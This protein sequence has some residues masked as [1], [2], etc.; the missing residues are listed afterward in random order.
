MT[1]YEPLQKVET[2]LL[3]RDLGGAIKDMEIFLSVHPHQINSDRLYAIQSD[4]QLMTDYWRRGYK[5]PKLPEL[6]D[7][8]LRRMYQLYANIAINYRVRHSSQLSDL[9]LKVQM[10]GRD[11]S[12]QVIREDLEAFVSDIALLDLE[13][14]HVAA[15]K[16]QAAYSHHQEL[17][18]TLFY[19]ILTAGLWTDGF[20]KNM[21]EMLLSPTIDS[22]DQQVLVSSVMLSAM[23]QFDIAKFRTLVNVYAQATD[24]NVRQR[25][26][27][28]W[29]FS[30]DSEV[31]QRLYPEE[32]KLVETLLESENC[33]RE[34]AELQRQ[35]TY[36]VNAERDKDALQNDIIPDL[37]KQQGWK[38]TRN[39]LVE[40]DEDDSLNDIL[41]PDE[42]ERKLEKLE[43]SFQ[44]ML[45]MQKQGADIYF[46]GFSLMK[47][48]SFFSELSNWFMPF[49][50][51]HPGIRNATKM[52][53]DNP[54]VQTMMN[55]APFCSSDKYSF[56]LAFEQ[57]FAKLPKDI[58]SMIARGEA[59]MVEVPAEESQ[60]PAYIRR[61]YLQ[62]LYR[63]F[64]VSPFN[65][66]F[67]NIF[68]DGEFNY[69]FFA[70]RIF[71]GTQ[72]EVYFND[73][74]AFMMKQGRYV[75][76]RNILLNYG[77]HRKDLNYYLMAGYLS[78]DAVESYRKAL[79]LDPENVRALTGF[80][81]RVFENGSYQEALEAYEKLLS[82]K[83][84]KMSYQLNKAVCLTNLGQYE[85][86]EKILFRLN[87]EYP[88]NESVSRSLAWTLTCNGKY[89]QADRLY[90]QLLSREEPFPDDFLNSGYCH[91]F[92]GHVD[93]AA[94][95]FH[96]F[97]K[98]TN[99]EFDYV[100]NNELEL[101]REKGIT[102][103]EIQ[104]M[105]YVL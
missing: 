55:G 103:P 16:L 23:T 77:E 86:A 58:R 61:L 69:V 56:I 80:A 47:R 89:N 57:V 88:D 83:P 37:L 97:L 82:L 27:V 8:L 54:F 68:E 91:W 22:I 34:L 18:S 104:M 64:R 85:E 26:L 70:D 20:A 41:H 78:I 28:G 53:K 32:V 13:P 100:V 14:P 44:R 48:F 25:A 75:E 67:F 30:I 43:A 42:E 71:S 81:R 9:F 33:C 24:E 59:R 76:A 36:T 62:D 45:D 19:H 35:I 95:C 92:S 105:R 84:E 93:E 2:Q 21:E 7:N 72:L 39:G 15:D 11:W 17:L 99:R 1:A 31:G 94:D 46:G 65:K 10:G 12:P 40:L 29:V 98:K 87:Y 66:C 49:F 6:Y 79:E 74:T 73:V 60:N 5:D 90:R 101:I 4:Y 102:E 3:K 63:F 50:I 52:F 38:A 96:H 51:N